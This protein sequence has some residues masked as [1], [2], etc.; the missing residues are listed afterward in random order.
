M[1]PIKYFWTKGSPTKNEVSE[2][3]QLAQNENCVVILKWKMFNSD[4]SMTIHAHSSFEDCE[5]QIPKVYGL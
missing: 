2:A 4:F 3:R 5:Q 1:I